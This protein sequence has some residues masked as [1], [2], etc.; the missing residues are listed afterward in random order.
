[1]SEELETQDDETQKE[2]SPLEEAKRIVEETKTA[3][4]EL[5]AERQKLEELKAIDVVSG[6]SRAGEQPAEKKEETAKEYAEKV[7][8][9]EVKGTKK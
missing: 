6:K 5:K 2:E 7:M 8:S 9:G 4:A 1:M 3:T